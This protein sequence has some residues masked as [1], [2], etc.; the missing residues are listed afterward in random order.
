VRCSSERGIVII[1]LLGVRGT[2]IEMNDDFQ[3]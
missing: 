3:R 2:G 1:A